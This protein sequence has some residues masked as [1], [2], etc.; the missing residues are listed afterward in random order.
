MRKQADW[1]VVLYT[2]LADEGEI[3]SEK[4]GG[5]TGTFSTGNES[6]CGF[7]IATDV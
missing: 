4:Y 3:N 5:V 7:T 1:I 2:S 6:T